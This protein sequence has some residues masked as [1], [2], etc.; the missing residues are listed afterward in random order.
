[1]RMAHAL[2]NLRRAARGR[3]RETVKASSV[4]ICTAGRWHMASKTVENQEKRHHRNIS[5]SKNPEPVYYS[6]N[7]FPSIFL[8]I[9]AFAEIGTVGIP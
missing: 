7:G 6:K 4:A 3:T 1:M 2:L 5:L 9:R 8:F